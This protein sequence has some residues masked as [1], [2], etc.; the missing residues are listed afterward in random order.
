MGYDGLK[1]LRGGWVRGSSG[2]ETLRAE[3]G[4]II[5]GICKT[6]N[7]Q[8]KTTT[9]KQ[10][11]NETRN[12]NKQNEPTTKRTKRIAFFH[13]W[14]LNRIG[15]RV[16]RE[17]TREKRRG[18]RTGRTRWWKRRR[19]RR[20]RRRIEGIVVFFFCYLS[21]FF[22]FSM[23]TM[24]PA[25]ALRSAHRPVSHR[26]YRVFLGID[27]ISLGLIGFDW[28]LPSLT[29]FYRV[30]RAF[31][32]FYWVLLGFTGFYLFLL[33]FYLVLPSFTGFY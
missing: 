16:C 26:I 9:T 10:Q 4:A 18:T 27:S 8:K 1:F 15:W 21:A 6:K 23:H 17:N 30:L 14:P 13:S 19:R 22:L 28:L 12:Q 2:V 5:G 32:G 3:H 7:K 29:D 33:S 20:R 31:T 11:N 24:A 25:A